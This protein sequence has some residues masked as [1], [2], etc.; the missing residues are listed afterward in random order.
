[1]SSK[2]L[3]R[4]WPVSIPA[5]LATSRV[6]AVAIGPLPRYFNTFQIAASF[7]RRHDSSRSHVQIAWYFSRSFALS[8]VNLACE[9]RIVRNAA[10]EIHY[11][12]SYLS[13][14]H[15]RQF[16]DFGTFDTAFR[17]LWVGIGEELKSIGIIPGTN[18]RFIFSSRCIR[19]AIAAR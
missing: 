7:G 10:Y 1:M 18:Y 16:C 19:S 8:R 15:D 14:V 17:L 11:D 6:P 2:L 13:A 12:L 3:R 5:K 4:D 9:D